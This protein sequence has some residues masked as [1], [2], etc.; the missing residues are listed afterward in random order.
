MAQKMLITGGCGFIGTNAAVYFSQ[1]GWDVHCIDNFSR[2]GSR[3]NADVIRA[4]APGVAIEEMDVAR[5]ADKLRGL[6]ESSGFDAIIHAAAQV[7]V[8]SSVTDPMH[9][10]SVN[11]LGTMHVLDAT[12]SLEKKPVVLFTSTNKVY[13]GLEHVALEEGATRYT[14]PALPNGVPEATPVDFHSPYGCSKG[15]ADQY[16]RDWNRIYGVPTVVFRQSCIY[17]QHQFGIVDQ[18][19]VVFLTMKALFDRPITIYGDGKQVRDV[20]FMDDLSHAFDA[21]IGNIG[22]TRGHIYNIGGGPAHSLSI[23]EF[24]RFVEDRLGKKL[25]VRFEGARPGDQKVYISDHTKASNHFGWS[26]TTS[27][28]AGFEKI[29]AWIE[30]NRASLEPLL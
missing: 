4:A 6:I 19:W 1:K 15:A 22:K 17:G 9:D 12:R 23:L 29:R 30:A 27:F 13:G 10:F 25:D 7:A 8:T 16:V 18:G 21:A 24:V 20:L 11:A 14:I 26:P 3:L 5:D 28:E 2:S